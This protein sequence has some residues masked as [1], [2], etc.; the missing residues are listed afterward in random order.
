M[1]SKFLPWRDFCELAGN[2]GIYSSQVSSF[3]G[4]YR[5]LYS[6]MYK[7]VSGLGHAS[8]HEKWIMYWGVKGSP[9]K[10]ASGHTDISEHEST[11]VRGTDAC[12]QL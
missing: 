7:I 1:Q 4:R 2:T 12:A 10:S 8:S 3:P 6:S 11:A 9:E 5:Y